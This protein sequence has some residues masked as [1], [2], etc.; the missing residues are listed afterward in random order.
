MVVPGD[1]FA[2]PLAPV[3]VP[4]YFPQHE[5]RTMP[6]DYAGLSDRIARG[7]DAVLAPLTRL[8]KANPRKAAVTLLVLGILA[9]L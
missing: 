2:G 7:F 5:V 6:I 9:V 8:V 4:V 3:V 1:P